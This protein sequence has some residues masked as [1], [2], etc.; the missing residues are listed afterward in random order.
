M[1]QQKQEYDYFLSTPT[2]YQLG[3]DIS[4]NGKGAQGACFYN[5]SIFFCTVSSD[6]ATQYLYK[7]AVAT[8]TTSLLK[9]YSTLGHANSM[10]YVPSK[11]AFYVAT[12]D[13]DMGIAIIDDTTYEH[14]SSI[15]IQRP[16]TG[17]NVIPYA[18]TWDRTNNVLYDIRNGFYRAYDADGNYIRIVNFSG[19]LTHTTEQGAETDG[20][21]IY[22]VW[23]AD[24]YVDVYTIGGKF[25]KTL[26]IGV[27]IEMEEIIYDWNG[28]FYADF[29]KQS[30]K[31]QLYSFMV[32]SFG[33][34]LNM[35]FTPCAV[36]AYTTSNG[37]WTKSGNNVLNVS[38]TA[39]SAGWNIVAYGAGYPYGYS[40]LNGKTCRVSFDVKRTNGSSGRVVFSAF[41]TNSDPTTAGSG[42]IYQAT[43]SK[44]VPASGS[45][46]YEYTGVI[47]TDWVK[48]ESGNEGTYIGYRIFW[49]AASGNACEISNI[50]FEVEV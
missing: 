45:E 9:T 39:S 3:S 21:Y 23:S 1:A 44:D 42:V 40:Y 6:G 29:Y 13:A 38:S 34:F 19:Y 33:G 26:T 25:V 12:M 2:Y 27:S 10:T 48:P 31:Q 24:N 14:T 47:G 11:N 17:A 5:D 22:K 16:D 36:W 20:K 7:Y 4:T 43:K 32:R 28:S 49:N 8:G 41:T 46:H 37:T 15:T 18:I 50:K 30:G 35:I